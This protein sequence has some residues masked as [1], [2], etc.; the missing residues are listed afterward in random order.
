MQGSVGI[1]AE[2]RVGGEALEQEQCGDFKNQGKAMCGWNVR[3]G[4][5]I[6]STRQVPCSPTAGLAHSQDKWKPMKGF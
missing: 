4:M 5:G 3:V 2:G 1:R 6:V